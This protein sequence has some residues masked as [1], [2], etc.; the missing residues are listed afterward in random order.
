[1]LPIAVQRV[2]MTSAISC[3]R[4]SKY[5]QILSRD[6]VDISFNMVPDVTAVHA[7]V[8]D[9]MGKVVANFTPSIGGGYNSF[10][11]DATG[12]DGRELAAGTYVLKSIKR[13]RD[14]DSQTYQTVKITAAAS[15]RYTYHSNYHP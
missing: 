2:R 12:K 10:V 3:L 11:W 4:T 1:M 6:Q 7:E 14:P 8:Y 9:I 5:S 13:H 15:S